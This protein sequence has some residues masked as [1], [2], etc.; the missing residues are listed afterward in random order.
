MSGFFKKSPQA[1][2]ARPLPEGARDPAICA[3]CPLYQ[4]NTCCLIDPGEQ[5]EGQ[6]HTPPE[7]GLRTA[8]TMFLDPGTYL[9]CS[10]GLSQ[11]Q[12]LCDDSHVGKCCE[13]VKFEI[14]RAKSVKLCGCKRTRTPPYCDGNQDNCS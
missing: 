7:A 11:D 9:W 6:R 8:L 4:A 12:P 2:P 10:C 1:A 5:P 13:P 3:E 14:T